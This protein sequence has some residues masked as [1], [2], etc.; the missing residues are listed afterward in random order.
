MKMKLIVAMKKNKQTTNW[1]SKTKL[2]FLLKQYSKHQKIMVW[3]I[4]EIFR[5]IGGN[6]L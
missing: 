6:A 1:L 3:T 4:N 5:K 2:T